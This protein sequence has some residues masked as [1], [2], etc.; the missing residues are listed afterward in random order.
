MKC[1]S[2]GKRFVH[3]SKTLEGDS[4]RAWVAWIAPRHR[5]SI[6]ACR[7]CLP[8]VLDFLMLEQTPYIQTESWVFYEVGVQDGLGT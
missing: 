8:L 6:Y 4:K 3:G 5:P 1:D 7:A 2:C